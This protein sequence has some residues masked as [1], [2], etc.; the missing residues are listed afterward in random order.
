MRRW[1]AAVRSQTSR[2]LIGN[3]DAW[4]S[5][6]PMTNVGTYAKDLEI[7]RAALESRAELRPDRWIDQPLRARI[8]GTDSQIQLYALD[9]VHWHGF[10]NVTAV[11]SVDQEQVERLRRQ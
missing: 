7:Q 6:A 1:R 5:C 3:H 9:S 11:G 10:G 8:P 4:C 2:E